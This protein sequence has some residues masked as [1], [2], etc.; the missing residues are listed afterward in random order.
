MR[1]VDAWEATY[2]LEAEFLV[3]VEEEDDED[4]EEGGHDA[5][6]RKNTQGEGSL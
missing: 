3:Q 2:F 6:G 5:H 4:E 1:F